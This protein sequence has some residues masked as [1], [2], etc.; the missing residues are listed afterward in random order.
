MKNQPRNFSGEVDVSGRAE[1]LSMWLDHFELVSVSNSWEGD[2]DKLQQV[3][4][5][6]VGEAEDWFMVNRDWILAKDATWANFKKEFISRFRP[7]NY[8]EEL[9]GRLRTPTMKIGESV[10]AY[11]TRY[12]RLHTQVNDMALTLDYCRNYWIAGLSRDIRKEVRYRE[13]T[14]FKRAVDT[15]SMIEAANCADEIDEERMQTGIH[16]KPQ[17]KNQSLDKVRG[18]FFAD[19]A[20]GLNSSKTLRGEHQKP[21]EKPD[22]V[23]D[24]KF[25]EFFNSMGPT[26][27]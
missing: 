12:Q 27:A 19:E 22:L 11:A 6:L 10:R 7:K 23:D 24:P 4:I 17:A 26:V 25:D 18:E 5:R 21:N 3:P 14:T 16:P 8:Q 1:D 9:A 13:P 15:A 2:K 20:A